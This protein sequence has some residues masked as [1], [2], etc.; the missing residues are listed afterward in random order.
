MLSSCFEVTQ[1]I[2]LLAESIKIVKFLT[3]VAFSIVGEVDEVSWGV[4]KEKDPTK[5]WAGP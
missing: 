5:V 3:P 2:I 1:T 4:K